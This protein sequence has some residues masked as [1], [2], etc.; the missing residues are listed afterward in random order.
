MQVDKQFF[1]GE[2]LYI[3]SVYVKGG[4]PAKI[5]WRKKYIDWLK[6][7]INFMDEMIQSLSDKNITSRD[8]EIVKR[9]IEGEGI[10]RF[11]EPLLEQWKENNYSLSPIKNL[12]SY[13]EVNQQMSSII[14]QLNHTVKSMNKK[15]K[16]KM[17]Y[18]LQALHNLPKVYLRSQQESMFGHPFPPISCA[19][20]LKCAQDYLK[21]ID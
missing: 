12:S 13:E 11:N 1:I 19:V 18:L 4:V 7:S 5:W 20:A 16:Q 6:N 14:E 10:F 21:M 9:I 15:N 3:L 2:A 17:W 8:Y